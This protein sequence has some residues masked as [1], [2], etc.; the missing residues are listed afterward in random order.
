MRLARALS[1][2]LSGTRATYIRRVD[3]HQRGKSDNGKSITCATDGCLG[4]AGLPPQRFLGG[5]AQGSVMVSAA[6]ALQM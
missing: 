4:C 3:V 1:R 5:A 2:T 6:E